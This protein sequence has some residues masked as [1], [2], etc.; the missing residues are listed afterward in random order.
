MSSAEGEVCRYTYVHV[1]KPDPGADLVLL[2]D[3]E[4]PHFFQ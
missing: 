3:L 2:V 1:V 4:C